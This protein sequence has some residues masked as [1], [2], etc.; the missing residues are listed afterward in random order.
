MSR[1]DDR[2]L[3]AAS[4]VV[5]AGRPPVTPGGPLNPPVVLSSTFH[6]GGNV[7][8]GRDANPTWEALEEAVGVLEGG[9]TV[10]FASGMGA[11]A[12]VLET[13]PTP[14]RVVVAGDAY[15]GTRRFLRDAASRGRLRFRTVDV[16]DTTGV[17]QVCTEL[18]GGPTRPSG[19]SGEFG[20][21]GVLWLESPTNPLLAIADLPALCDGAHELGMDVVVDNTFATPLL[22][23]PLALGADAVVHSA[24]KLLAGHSDVLAGLVCSARPE[25][26]DR[27]LTRRSLHGAALGPWEAWLT[28]RGM[29]TLAIRLERSQANAAVLAERLVGHGAVGRVRY[30]GLVADP[31]HDLA[32]RQMRGYGTMVSFEV[33]GG[34]ATAPVAEAVVDA[35]RLITAG[36]SLG[37]VESLIERRG[38]WEGEGGV[39]SGLIRLSVGIEDIE[40]LW[41]DLDSALAAVAHP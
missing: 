19:R 24:T 15:N 29:R 21:G 3:S 7:V 27:M 4:L 12:A 41:R 40:D 38:R 36:T 25:V 16:A 18:A 2:N 9:A 28:L 30:P 11:V 23:T 32:T 1:S 20:S 35:T 33:A 14:G 39:P 34:G 37:G 8:Y 5:H 26:V 6:Q 17:L 10:A 31:G 22:Q 13:L